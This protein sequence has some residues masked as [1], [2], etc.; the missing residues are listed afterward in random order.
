MKPKTT[1]AKI[2]QLAF[3]LF[4]ITLLWYFPNHPFAPYATFFIGWTL[5]TAIVDVAADLQK[6]DEQTACLVCRN[7][8]LTT[9]RATFRCRVCGKINEFKESS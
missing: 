6:R 5:V 2:V 9:I 1:I 3:S 8:A 7:T 4:F